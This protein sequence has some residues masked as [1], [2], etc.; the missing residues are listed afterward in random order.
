VRN[1]DNTTDD[2]ASQ[3]TGSDNFLLLPQ[4][5]YPAPSEGNEADLFNAQIGLHTIRML[6]DRYL[7]FIQ[8]LNAV[9]SHAEVLQAFDLTSATQSISSLSHIALAVLC[10][11]AMYRSTPRS[12]RDALLYH[13]RHRRM[14]I[15]RSSV[16]TV[17][18]LLILSQS[19]E[20]M[21]PDTNDAAG[22]SINMLGLA[23]RMAQDLGMH[24]DLSRLGVD[25]TRSR[26]FARIWSALLVQD[27]WYSICYGQP[28]LIQLEDCDVSPPSPFDDEQD[29]AL[30]N[31]TT[32]QPF[33]SHVAHYEMCLLMGRLH[34]L[35]F[36]LRG[37]KPTSYAEIV[38]IWREIEAWDSRLP[39]ALCFATQSASTDSQP[40]DAGWIFS[41][42]TTI[43]YLVYRIALNIPGEMLSFDRSDMWHMLIR[44]SADALEWLSSADGLHCL[45]SYSIT[46]YFLV[47]SSVIQYY[48]ACQGGSLHSL[49][50]AR[51]SLQNQGSVATAATTHSQ[52]YDPYAPDEQQRQSYKLGEST[53]SQLDIV[54]TSSSN[55]NVTR[56]EA[57]RTESSA[58][59][60]PSTSNK[61]TKSMPKLLRLRVKISALLNLLLEIAE[62]RR[63]M[64]LARM[65][66]SES[67]GAKQSS[68]R[69]YAPAGVMHDVKLTLPPGMMTNDGPVG[70]GPTS[71]S[72]NR[73]RGSSYTNGG[74]VGTHAMHHTALHP[75]YGPSQ[76]SDAAASYRYGGSGVEA[77]RSVASYTGALDDHN[78]GG[79]VGAASYPLQPSVRDGPTQLDAVHAMHP[80]AGLGNTSPRQIED[81]DLMTLQRWADALL[82][83]P[84]TVAPSTG[85]VQHLNS[86]SRTYI[87]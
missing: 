10:L 16:E 22:M 79:L 67:V 50:V 6:M 71:T 33:Q 77:G 24:R 60:D 20:M 40:I 57:A 17:Q 64:V 48:S 8:P 73:Y 43:E 1:I 85:D 47:Q 53:P 37:L 12:A 76:P 66:G 70:F 51:Q 27:R 56:P 61:P 23:I 42:R 38:Q 19:I 68:K 49:R 58:D 34:K 29:P 65:E 9:L 30:A 28:H 78:M 86:S 80:S 55:Q 21:A 13:Q 5:R 84:T 3:P 59:S 14:S 36:G 81:L 35:A 4:I 72:A 11:A 41:M 26:R 7:T 15:F 74:D 63:A 46:L 69:K 45:D 18:S 83:N 2:D 82:R 39:S 75:H 31:A 62:Q 54:N 87:M 52:I 32:R 25:S 44:K